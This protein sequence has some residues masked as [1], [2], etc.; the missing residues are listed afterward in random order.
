MS[1]QD[2]RCPSCNNWMLSGDGIYIISRGEC[3][4]EY[5]SDQYDASDKDI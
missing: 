3:V 1:D 2:V 4:C 5:C